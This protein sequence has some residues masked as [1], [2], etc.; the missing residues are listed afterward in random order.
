MAHAAVNGV[1]PPRH[2]MET[3]LLQRFLPTTAEKSAHITATSRLPKCGRTLLVAD[4][5]AQG[6]SGIPNAMVTISPFLNTLIGREW[7]IWRLM[8]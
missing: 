5:P 6:T 7:I 1:T 2:R 3:G 8:P 4:Q